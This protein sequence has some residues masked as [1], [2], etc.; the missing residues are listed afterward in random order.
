MSKIRP[1]AGDASDGGGTEGC[2]E[3]WITGEFM[4]RSGVAGGR[5]GEQVEYWVDAIEV[6]EAWKDGTEKQLEGIVEEE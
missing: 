3:I 2:G 5:A 1:W 4:P 6:V